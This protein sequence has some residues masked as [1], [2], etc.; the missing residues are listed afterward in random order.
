MTPMIRKLEGR[1]LGTHFE[2]M[3]M[4]PNTELYTSQ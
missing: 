4:L 2:V 1:S 3:C